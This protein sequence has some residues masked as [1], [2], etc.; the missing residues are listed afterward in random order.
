MNTREN[1]HKRQNR[2]FPRKI[3]ISIKSKISK[4][5][6]II[7]YPKKTQAEKKKTPFDSKQKPDPIIDTTQVHNNKVGKRMRSK[8]QEPVAP[9]GACTA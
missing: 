5:N 6:P 2:T 1:I 9:R 3:F 7:S 8:W 4:S